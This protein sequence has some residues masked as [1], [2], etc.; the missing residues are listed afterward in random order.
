MKLAIRYDKEADIMTIDTANGIQ[1]ADSSS[2]EFGLVADFGSE[3]GMDVVGIEIHAVSQHLAPF[4]ALTEAEA[5]KAQK[6]VTKFNIK[7]GYDKEA[8]I[9]TIHTQRDIVSSSNVGGG[10]VAY[11]GYDDV[12]YEDTYDVVGVALHNASECLAPHFKLNRAPLAVAGGG[13]D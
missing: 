11:F 5:V 1:I 12:R 7:Y 2:V 4:C 9:L 13:S 6:A 3:D 8:D 10:L